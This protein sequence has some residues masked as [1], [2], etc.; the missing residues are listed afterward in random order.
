MGI[1]G[2][3]LHFGYV[4]SA[5][6]AVMI[7]GSQGAAE[8]LPKTAHEAM[9]SVAK[10]FCEKY[11]E[12][13]EVQEDDS[14]CCTEALRLRQKYCPECGKRPQKAKFDTEEYSQWCEQQL[15]Q[16]AD[17]WGGYEGDWWPWNTVASTLQW[18][19][20]GHQILEIKEKAE[21]WLV[22]ALHPDDAPKSW[23]SSLEE[24]HKGFVLHHPLNRLSHNNL[25]MDGLI[26][27]DNKLCGGR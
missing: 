11:K 15:H 2:V 8:D 22:A 12:D 18:A 3:V 20:D 19:K 26:D 24:H 21:S 14:D 16:T 27:K 10:F 5:Q 4:E 7:L 6:V 17:D 1:A 9:R 25:D 23:R 13:W